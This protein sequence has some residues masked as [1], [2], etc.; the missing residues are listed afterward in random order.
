MPEMPAAVWMTPRSPAIFMVAARIP[1]LSGTCDA[2]A[3]GGSSPA[4]KLVNWVAQAAAIPTVHVLRNSLL[5]VVGLAVP[6]EPFDLFPGISFCIGPAPSEHAFR[7]S[8]SL[9]Q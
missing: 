7:K 9:G 8:A 1:N 3:F 4:P 6:C 5:F 2:G